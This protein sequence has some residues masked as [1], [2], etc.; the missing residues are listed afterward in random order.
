MNAA[1]ACRQKLFFVEVIFRESEKTLFIWLAQL[2]FF[3][4]ST[5]LRIE[6]VPGF[7]LRVASSSTG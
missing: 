2:T 5:A 4:Q 1:M 3:I 7:K 6:L